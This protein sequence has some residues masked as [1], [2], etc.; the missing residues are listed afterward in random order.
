MFKKIAML[1]LV[2]GVGI[3]VLAGCS[4]KS[5]RRYIEGKAAELS[6]VYPTE[7]LEDLF[8]KFPDGFSITTNDLYDYNEDGSYSLQRISLNGDSNKKQ[9]SGNIQEK[10]IIVDEKG[11]ISEKVVYDG[12]IEY[13]NSVLQLKDQQAKVTI[14]HP[15][16][17]IQKFTIKKEFLS[18][19]SLNKKSY[20]LETGSAHISYFLENKELSDYMTVTQDTKLKMVIYIMYETMENKAYNYTID[21]QNGHNSYS[22]TIGG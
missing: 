20:S 22:E 6:K 12:D 8:E 14:R 3:M 5:S 16:L 15:K 19:L 11:K 2:G 13:Q 21:I 10:R 9:F 17:L 18:Q 4:L 1:M 7:N